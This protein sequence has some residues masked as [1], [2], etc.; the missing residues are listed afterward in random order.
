MQNEIEYSWNS[1]LFHF[2]FTP[3]QVATNLSNK[4]TSLCNP[5]LEGHCPMENIVMIHNNS[6]LPYVEN[7]SGKTLLKITVEQVHDRA[8][9]NCSLHQLCSAVFP[10]CTSL[11]MGQNETANNTLTVKLSESCTLHSDLLMTLGQIST[12]SKTDNADVNMVPIVNHSTSLNGSVDCHP[13]YTQV[14]GLCVPRCSQYHVHL[15]TNGHWN[16]EELAV[17]AASGNCILGGVIFIVLSIAR[18]KEM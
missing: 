13:Q 10:Q 12:A 4:I 17:I 11:N 18:R 9:L 16:L 14:C 15:Q 1:S 3:D 7:K 5:Y 8:P 2:I 6:I